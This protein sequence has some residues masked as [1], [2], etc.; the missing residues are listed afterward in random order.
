MK[1]RRIAY[2]ETELWWI[3]GHRDLPRKEAYALFCKTFARDDV[4]FD[5]FKALCTRK[6]WTTGRT[7][8][9]EKGSVPANKGKT[10]PFNANSAKTQFKKGQLPHNTKHLGH[11]RVC[12]DGYV[13]ISV[14]ET[15][16]HAGYERRYVLKHRWLWEK[17]NGPVPDGHVLKCLDG[18]RT[19]TD[20]A[21]WV[22]IPRAMLPR[23]AGRQDLGKLGYDEASPELKPIILTT[24]QLEHAGRQAR[25]DMPKGGV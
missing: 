18:D 9:F 6:G 15:N 17:A 20:P 11:E 4:I 19:N 14:D 8:R 16:P 25:K 10:M 24:A 23:L 2:S 5:N 21:N 1:R 3:E 7:G 13:E 22:A 12:K